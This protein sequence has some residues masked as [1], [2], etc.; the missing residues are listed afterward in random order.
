M[1]SPQILVDKYYEI[2]WLQGAKSLDTAMLLILHFHFLFCFSL[3]Q[4]CFSLSF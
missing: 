4:A 1:V 3:F 2:L